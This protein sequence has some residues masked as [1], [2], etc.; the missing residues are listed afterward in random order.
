MTDLRR[1]SLVWV[2]AGVLLFVMAGVQMVAATRRQEAEQQRRDAHWQEVNVAAARSNPRVLPGEEKPAPAPLEGWGWIA[3]LATVATGCVGWGG[4][5]WLQR[6]RQPPT[7]LPSDN[8][9]DL[10]GPG[11]PRSPMAD[12]SQSRTMGTVPRA[13]TLPP[14]PA[15]PAVPARGS[16]P[17]AP[18]VNPLGRFPGQSSGPTSLP[19]AGP[20]SRPGAAPGHSQ[21]GRD[22]RAPESGR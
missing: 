16:L 2:L 4:V 6:L 9:A 13:S 18:A 1:N 15:N 19:A 22:S 3:L 17:G 21:G 10:T 12:P 14:L 7:R 11:R 5:L 20:D 8:G